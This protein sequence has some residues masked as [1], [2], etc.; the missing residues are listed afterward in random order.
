[1]TEELP[2]DPEKLEQR[3]KA[4]QAEAGGQQ[5]ENPEE[6][7]RDAKEELERKKKKME[8]QKKRSDELSKRA[9]RAMDR[10]GYDDED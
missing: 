7:V 1:M 8:Q 3:I 9:D 6:T 10:L 2:N 5:N 4:I